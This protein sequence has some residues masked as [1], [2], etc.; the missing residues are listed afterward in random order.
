MTEAYMRLQEE[1]AKLSA[2]VERLTA[3]LQ[4]GEYYINR[5]EAAQRGHVVRD[6][7][8]ACN[9]WESYMRRVSI[10]DEQSPGETK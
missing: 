1:N 5:L 9:A 7:D 8:E 2:R 10:A 6:M 4:R 3:A